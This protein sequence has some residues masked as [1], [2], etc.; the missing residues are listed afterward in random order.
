MQLPKGPATN[1]LAAIIVIV[2]LPLYLTGEMG[3]AALIAG[4]ISER[5]TLL[6]SSEALT[7]NV[8]WLPLWITPLTATLLHGGWM[9]LGFNVLMLIFCGRFVENL[10]GPGRLVVI[11]VV[12]AYAAALGQWLSSFFY[13]QGEGWVPMIGASGAIS[14]V[15]GTY[16]FI[17]SQRGVKAIGPV[18][19]YIV[20]MVWLGAAWT[21][22]QLLIAL[23]GGFDSFFG[24]IAV[25]AHIGGFIAGL[26]LAR[27]LLARRFRAS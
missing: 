7:F 16:A 25:G 13:A 4:F 9:H 3:R 19:A 12:G 5:V 18:P 17:Y 22:L 11:Y 2:F 8:P 14:A 21:I 1:I 6:S 20:R 27:P 26:L 24:G 23:A 10:L 15:L